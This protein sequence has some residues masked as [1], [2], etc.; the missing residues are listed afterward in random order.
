MKKW[1]LT[2]EIPAGETKEQLKC[3]RQKL[4]TAATSRELSSALGAWKP[5][6]RK[7]T[8]SIPGPQL[9][10]K[11]SFLIL[12][13]FSHTRPYN[14][15]LIRIIYTK[16]EFSG[17]LVQQAEKTFFLILKMF[18][19]NSAALSRINSALWISMLHV[20]G[21]KSQKTVNVLVGVPHW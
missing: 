18:V 21:K 20:L 8:R 2:S 6:N 5:D 13:K 12:F 1:K 15:A 17:N 3:K 19:S 10:H 7:L 16:S 14:A 11:L 4:W 9:E